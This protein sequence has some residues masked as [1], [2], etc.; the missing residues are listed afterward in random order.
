MA[1][2]AND[3]QSPAAER[4]WTALLKGVQEARRTHQRAALGRE[5]YKDEAAV[6]DR[7]AVA[8]LGDIERAIQHAQRAV[9]PPKIE[10]SAHGPHGSVD[11][12]PTA[13]DDTTGMPAAASRGGSPS[14]DARPDGPAPVPVDDRGPEASEPQ[15][16][17]EN[18]ARATRMP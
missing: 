15:P 8:V 11:F 5:K 7:I 1:D 9:A 4:F 16:E 17:T 18:E 12:A 13:D 14:A 6:A 10:K 3:Q 2:A